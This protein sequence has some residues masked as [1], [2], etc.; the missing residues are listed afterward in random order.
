MVLNQIM[1]INHSIIDHHQKNNET[2]NEHNNGRIMVTLN[3]PIESLGSFKA[4]LFIP[5]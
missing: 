4:Q 3:D 5:F 1:A 2:N